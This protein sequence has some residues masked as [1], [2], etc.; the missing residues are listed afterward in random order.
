MSLDKAM[1]NMKFDK[2]LQEWSM[3]TGQL[4]KEELQKQLDALPDLKDK[5]DIVNLSD[6]RA[7]PDAH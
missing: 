3:T 2:R 4:S 6:D 1:K 5:V 7:K